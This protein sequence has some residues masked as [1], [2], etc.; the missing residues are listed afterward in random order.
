M[1]SWE[2]IFKQAVQAIACPLTED[3]LRLFKLFRTEL[4]TWNRN[5]SLLSLKTPYDLPV[6][7]FADSLTV[8]PLLNDTGE[9]R[10]LRLLDLGTGAGFPG[11]PLK[12]M[13]ESLFVTLVDAS[14]KKT[15]FLK[16]VLRTLDLERVTVI[17]ARIE[18][19][20]EG[21]ASYDYVVSRATFSLAELITVAHS[22]LSPGGTLISMKGSPSGDEV[23]RAS[24]V[25]SELDMEGMERREI[26]LPLVNGKRTLFLIRKIRT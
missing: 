22:F 11:I 18:T 13:R 24:E 19:I 8:L 26:T 1:E 21:R 15:S 25:L 10:T 16:H 9:E 12:I 7:H 6:K 5:M 17:N 14:R 3:R 4:L 2:D 23:Q 20:V